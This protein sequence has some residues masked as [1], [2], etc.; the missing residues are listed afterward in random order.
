[1][2]CLL[3]EIDRNYDRLN[4]QRSPKICI[5]MDRPEDTQRGDHK[6]MT[7]VMFLEK[8][9][10]NRFGRLTRGDG[11]EPFEVQDDETVGG[12]GDQTFAF[13]PAQDAD[14]GFRGGTDH[15]SHILSG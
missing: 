11:F 6:N 8:P 3:F 13:E 5:T 9:G 4:R 14:H 15:I 7:K 1:M 10:R 12:S 2:D